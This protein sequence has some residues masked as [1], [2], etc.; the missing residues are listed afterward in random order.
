MG[1]PLTYGSFTGHKPGTGFLKKAYQDS[2]GLIDEYCDL[3]G[4]VL[5]YMMQ[6]KRPAFSEVYSLIAAKRDSSNNPTLAVEKSDFFLIQ[7]FILS[8]FLDHLN[9]ETK[10]LEERLKLTLQFDSSEFRAKAGDKIVSKAL[11]KAKSVGQ[12][13]VQKNTSAITNNFKLT[14]HFKSLEK[15]LAKGESDWTILKFDYVNSQNL[16]DRKIEKKAP[17]SLKLTKTIKYG[18]FSIKSLAFLSRYNLI[19][20]LGGMF[21]DALIS[22]SE[23]TIAD[24]KK[25]TD[26]LKT[27]KTRDQYLDALQAK[28]TNSAQE[29][30]KNLRED[31]NSINDKSF[32]END[33]VE[34]AIFQTQMNAYVE[35]LKEFCTEF[36]LPINEKGLIDHDIDSS[37]L[38]SS[39]LSFIRSVGRTWA[40]FNTGNEYNDW[41]SKGVFGP[42][43][44]QWLRAISYLSKSSWHTE[45]VWNQSLG[46]YVDE[47]DG[48]ENVR[49]VFIDQFVHEGLKFGIRYE[50]LLK[51]SRKIRSEI[52]NTVYERKHITNEPLAGT[53]D[54]Q[55]RTWVENKYEGMEW[56]FKPSQ[57][58]SREQ[59]LFYYKEVASGAD[60]VKSQDIVEIGLKILDLNND[61]TN[62]LLMLDSVQFTIK[63]DDNSIIKTISG[64]EWIAGF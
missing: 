22:F 53:S 17:K 9:E 47:I 11:K 49:H 46:S 3:Y 19:T 27:I 62:D 15:A 29:L 24:F 28:Y 61:V 64:T 20:F 7:D 39:N 1:E 14:T 57:L 6:K 37:S 12:D 38:K 10:S 45:E 30:I 41:K 63:Y 54:D 50:E 42:D 18:S 58:V 34:A 23:D 33:E 48:I 4:S 51:K 55:E 16:Y 52:L 26:F 2:Q 8:R 21:V 40:L 35:A 36:T 25:M 43:K 5:S 44:V 56:K 60:K 59:T 13:Y 32:N 31:L